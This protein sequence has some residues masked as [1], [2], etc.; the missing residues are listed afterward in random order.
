M[1]VYGALMWSLGKVFGTPEV[2]RVYVGSFWDQPLRYEIN[3]RLFYAEEQDLLSDLHS[4]TRNATL[5]KVNDLIKRIRALKVHAQLVGEIRQKMPLFMGKQAKKEDILNNLD[6]IFA[7]LIQERSIPI[8]DFP[9]V[10]R[11]RALLEPLD[12]SKLPKLNP[13]HLIQL[14]TMLKEDLTNLVS[15]LQI[16]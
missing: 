10:K 5:R 9:E 14:D 13:R 1:R 11:I 7:T 3:Q 6:D 16:L 15:E 12:F 8:G 4:L 2:A